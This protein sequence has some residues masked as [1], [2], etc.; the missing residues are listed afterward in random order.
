LILS[1]A[2]PGGLVG[3]S[4]PYAL[5]RWGADSENKLIESELMTTVFTIE[6][7]QIIGDI[8]LSQ[9]TASDLGASSSTDL[10]ILAIED[11][12]SDYANNFAEQLLNNNWSFLGQNTTTH[13]IRT[14]NEFEMLLIQLSLI[15][16]GACYLFRHLISAEIDCLMV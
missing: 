11:A 5:A 14:L 15:L 12:N 3:Q 6:D 16:M 7:R 2:T 13:V 4:E 10:Y 8:S 1:F 9:P